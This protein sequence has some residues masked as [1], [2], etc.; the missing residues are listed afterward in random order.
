MHSQSRHSGDGHPNVALEM[1][2]LIGTNISTDI[3]IELRMLFDIDCWR[4]LDVV[5]TRYRFKFK[6]HM[7][8]VLSF[9]WMVSLES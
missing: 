5:A 1:K 3:G 8:T 4:A 7:Q 6:L 2:V 9:E